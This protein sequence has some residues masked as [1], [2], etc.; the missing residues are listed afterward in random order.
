LAPVFGRW[1][2]KLYRVPSAAAIQ[3]IAQVGAARKTAR[4]LTQPSTLQRSSL[5]GR[6]RRTGQIKGETTFPD[7]TYSASLNRSSLDP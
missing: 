2:C 4:P 5:L 1:F 3:A 6:N 7:F